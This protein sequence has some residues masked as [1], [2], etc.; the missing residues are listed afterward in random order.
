MKKKVIQLTPDFG[1]CIDW[2]TSG[3]TW[4]GDSSKDYQGISFG[5]VVFKTGSFEVIE[6][7]YRVIKFD[8]T[9][10]KWSEE[11]QGVHGLTREFLA[12]DGVSQEEA[13]QDLLEL[14]IK[15]FG[16][17]KVMFLGHNT[18]F[19]RRFTN[20]LTKSVGIEFSVEHSGEPCDGRIEIHHVVLDTSSTGFIT[21][22]LFKSDLLFD[23]VGLEER[24]E[25]NALTDALYTVETCA[26]I[27]LLV[28]TALEG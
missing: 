25:H 10:Y 27:R 26:R 28:K 19:D 21:M 24:G 11:A 3:S 8:E 13:A 6:T 20:Q 18:E 1:L 15:Y 12:A 14:I 4:G 17:N 2:E 22:G 23:A 7:L 9:K 16:T 5:A